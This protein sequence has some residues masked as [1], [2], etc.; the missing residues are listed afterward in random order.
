VS[1]LVGKGRHD[2]KPR[3]WVPL[4][5]Q[6]VVGLTSEERLAQ[7]EARKAANRARFAEQKK[8]GR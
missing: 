7:R 3:T 8:A 6:S 4:P 1:V 5:K 2:P